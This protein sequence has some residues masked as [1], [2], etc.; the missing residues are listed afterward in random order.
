[1]ALAAY[2]PGN[3]ARASSLRISVERLRRALL[4]LMV[5]SSS[6]VLI[7]P[8]PY[9]VLFLCVAFI[10]A[11]TGLRLPASVAPLLLLITAFNIG[12][13]FALVPFLDHEPS[14]MFVIISVYMGF[15]AVFFACLMTENTESR[16]DTI[17][18]AWIF[19]GVIASLCGFAGYINLGGTGAIF[20]LYGR[21]TGTFKDPNVLG[22]FLTVPAALIVQ[23][24]MTGTLKRPLISFTCLM[25]LLGGIFF[26]FS[27]GAWG[28]TALAFLMTGFLLFVTTRSI[29]T[30]VRIVVIAIAGA[31]VLAM[32]LA[33]VLSIDSVWQLFEIRA[34]LKQDYDTG[35]HGRFGK[36]LDAIPML[37]DRPN[38]FGPLRFTD[39]FP[40]APHDVFVN[41]FS[42]Y[43]W[44]GGISYFCLVAIIVWLGWSTVWRRTPW[45]GT[46]IALWSVTF[47][48]ILQGFQ[49]DTDHWR[50]LWLLFG[51]TWGLAI[52]SR[53]RRRPRTATRAPA[54]AAVLSAQHASAT[55]R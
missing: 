51:L 39:Y 54:R 27:R 41:A 11:V 6:I 44:L 19:A 34:S 12:G 15:S 22:P 52:V 31:A 1:M 47:G 29:S 40:E 16:L 21:V 24:F 46:Y 50:H 20:T 18:K 32:G 25:I 10:Y 2:P 17:S 23:G 49:I 26:S 14:V 5:A 30:R 3:I 7:E 45:Q 42:S 43:G 13:A 36:L 48:Q 55:G 37:L 38:G 8:A 4:W 28:V 53:P 33:A 35:A 9:D